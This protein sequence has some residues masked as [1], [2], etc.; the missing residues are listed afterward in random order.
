M[1]WNFL[2]RRLNSHYGESQFMASTLESSFGDSRFR[3]MGRVT[4]QQNPTH[5]SRFKV[6]VACKARYEKACD[7]VRS[8]GISDHEIHDMSHEAL[9]RLIYPLE[10]FTLSIYT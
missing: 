10:Y 8:S 1:P 6:I 9:T 2:P 4:I 7:L 3:N 5:A